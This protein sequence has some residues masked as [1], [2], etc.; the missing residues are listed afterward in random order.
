MSD[1]RG[2][3]NCPVCGWNEPPTAHAGAEIE[4]LQREVRRWEDWWRHVAGQL[5]VVRSDSATSTGKRLCDDLI[6]GRGA[7]L[8][9]PWD[10]P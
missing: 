3:Y 8:R 2:T 9:A 5:A 7:P 4:C 1:P 10:Q 6:A